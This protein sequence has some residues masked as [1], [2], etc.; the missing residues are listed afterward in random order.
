MSIYFL[1]VITISLRID[2]YSGTILSRILVCGCVWMC[3]SLFF[4]LKHNVGHIVSSTHE[5]EMGLKAFPYKHRDIW[6][7]VP[8]NYRW[9]RNIWSENITACISH[10]HFLFLT[11][12]TKDVGHRR[13]K[14]CPGDVLKTSCKDC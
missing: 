8:Q 5:N 7:A 2:Q 12:H 10:A 9:L 13:K 1:L 14:F 4:I 11:N 3:F 6:P